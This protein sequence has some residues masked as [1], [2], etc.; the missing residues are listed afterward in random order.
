MTEPYE[1]YKR[2]KAALAS[3]CTEE[4][5]KAMRCP[6]CG[7]ALIFRV[8]PRTGRTFSVGCGKAEPPPDFWLVEDMIGESPEWWRNYVGGSWYSGEPFTRTAE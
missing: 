4:Q 3:G 2:I 6:K 8:S 5:F 1:E 7:A